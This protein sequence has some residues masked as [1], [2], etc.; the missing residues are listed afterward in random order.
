MAAGV[1]LM[2]RLCWVMALVVS[3][4][5]ASAQSRP[6]VAS[7][8]LQGAQ[9]QSSQLQGVRRPPLRTVG[10]DMLREGAEEVMREAIAVSQ[11]LEG[12]SA[13]EPRVKLGIYTSAGSDEC[14][15][16]FHSIISRV[17]QK[18]GMLDIIDLEMVFWGDGDVVDENNA[19]L[20]AEALA[21]VEDASAVNFSC[22]RH[23]DPACAGNAWEACLA[24]QFPN[25]SD[26]FPVLN[27]I[28]GRACADD[29][30]APDQCYGS[31]PEVAPVCAR[32]FGEG[33]IDADA[34]SECA[35][36]ENGKELLL[37]NAQKTSALDPP[38]EFLPWILVD[39]QALGAGAGS[40]GRDSQLLLG[41]A[42]CDAYA[43][44][45]ADEPYA[46]AMFPQSLQDL[47][48]PWGEGVHCL[49]R[50]SIC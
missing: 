48:D 40:S 27:C 3:A 5:R 14:R 32:E 15:K 19:R 8:L 42:I 10:V 49:S 16:V 13:L 41:K 23:G 22:A 2:L 1:R 7:G 43:L 35:S 44:K 45:G 20:D 11:A 28:E 4:G 6:A 38:I 36:G 25:P 39:G 37:S 46:C 21:A 9:S 29:E 18:E 12:E 30:Q 47:T 24:S 26:F 31:V 33:L 34:L 50:P 17:L